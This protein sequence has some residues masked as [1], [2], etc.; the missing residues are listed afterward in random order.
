M[1]ATITA[2]NFPRGFGFCQTANGK[3]FFIHIRNWMENDPPAVGRKIFFDVAPP[4]ANGKSPMAVKVRFA[5]DAEIS[6]V[7]VGA[8]ALKAVVS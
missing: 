8:D 7:S 3:D 4:I 5:S 6:N 1:I 2:W